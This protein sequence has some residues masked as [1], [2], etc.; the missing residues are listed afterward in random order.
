MIIKHRLKVDDSLDV[1]AVHGIGGATGVVLTSVFA[2][3]AFGGI[4]L[5]E[6]RSI[7]EQLVIQLTGTVA[8]LIWSLVVSFVIIKIVQFVVGL[9]VSA[10]TEEQGLDLNIHGERGYNM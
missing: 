1:L 3:A 7:G 2:A 4:G 8:V 5:A 6:G 9:R 10:E